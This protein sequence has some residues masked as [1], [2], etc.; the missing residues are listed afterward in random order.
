MLTISLVFLIIL[1]LLLGFGIGIGFLLHW[2][3]PAI[4]L[5]IAT[6]IGIVAIGMAFRS[7]SRLMSSLPEAGEDV[8][9]G[10][11]IREAVYLI[12]P[13]AFRRRRK[14]RATRQ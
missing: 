8:E 10:N 5:G 13:D 7:L 3:I 1:A 6:L 4:E 9:D 12:E 14:R 2:L 11:R